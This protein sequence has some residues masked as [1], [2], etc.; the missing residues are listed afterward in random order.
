MEN[1]PIKIFIAYSHK[2]LDLLEELRM[3]FAPLEISGKVTVWYDGEIRPGDK[4]EERIYEELNSAEI[5]LLLVSQYSIFSKYFYE[6]EVQKA[7][8][9]DEKG[10]TK[11][12]PVILRPCLWQETP[13]GKLQALPENGIAIIN[14]A[15]IDSGYFNVVETLKRIVDDLLWERQF[16]KHPETASKTS[17]LLHFTDSEGNRIEYEGEIIRGKA[18]GYGTAKSLYRNSNFVYTGNFVNNLRHD[19]NAKSVFG[20][21]KMRAGSIF[22]VTKLRRDDK[23]VQRTY[24][25]PM[26]CNITLFKPKTQTNGKLTGCNRCLAVHGSSRMPMAESTS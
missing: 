23:K 15:P 24:R 1:E 26:G 19:D 5:I 21:F 10:E 22:G 4:W 25:L 9:R 11:V 2:D 8:Q 7:I 17:G 12:I 14:W 3:Q 20:N 16:E 13:L 6:S 18:N